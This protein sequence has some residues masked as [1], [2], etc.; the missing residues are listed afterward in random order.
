MAGDEDAD[1]EEVGECMYCQQDVAKVGRDVEF[2]GDDIIC[3]DCGE[4]YT[5]GC[6]GCDGRAFTNGVFF[7]E[8]QWCWRCVLLAPAIVASDESGF[9]HAVNDEVL[10]GESP[11]VQEAVRKLA[12]TFQGTV[13]EL[14]D[15]ARG[16][17]S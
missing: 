12:A 4:L 15:V 8:K 11:Q 1:F 10:P 13:G 2:S 3:V 5:G 14:L 7:E 17:T 9:G 6:H 16:A